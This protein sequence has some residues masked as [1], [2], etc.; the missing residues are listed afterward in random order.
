VNTNLEVILERIDAAK[1]L[2]ER[3][4]EIDISSKEIDFSCAAPGEKEEAQEWLS[5]LKTER[6]L[7]KEQLTGMR[8]SLKVEM[9]GNLIPTD[10]IAEMLAPLQLSGDTMDQHRD[11]NTDAE[12]NQSL[13]DLGHYDEDGGRVEVNPVGRKIRYRRSMEQ[14]VA[15]YAAMRHKIEG[16]KPRKY[17]K[18]ED[19]LIL[20]HKIDPSIKPSAQ[21]MGK[22][23]RAAVRAALDMAKTYVQRPDQKGYS[24]AANALR[25]KMARPKK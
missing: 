7:M 11:A 23:E 4:N 8:E 2:V 13:E 22:S 9:A 20:C 25:I 10:L 19:F 6:S 21:N 5:S 1:Q 24:E 3:I 16:D 14:M 12:G 15:W 17:N 18:L